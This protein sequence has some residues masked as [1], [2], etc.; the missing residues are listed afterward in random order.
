MNMRWVYYVPLKDLIGSHQIIGFVSSCAYNST[1]P[2]WHASIYTLLDKQFSGSVNLF[3]MAWSRDDGPWQIAC[4]RS[5][6]QKTLATGILYCV[7]GLIFWNLWYP[8]IAFNFYKR[9]I[10]SIHIAGKEGPWGESERLIRLVDHWLLHACVDDLSWL[11][12]TSKKCI[13]KII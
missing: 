11:N 8:Y 10:S 12:Y 6:S 2:S 7:T 9:L 3:N 5:Y 4:L 1:I 13:I